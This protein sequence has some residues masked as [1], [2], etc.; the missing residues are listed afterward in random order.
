MAPGAVFNCFPRERKP[1]RGPVDARIQVRGAIPVNICSVIRQASRRATDVLAKD[2]DNLARSFDTENTGGLLSGFLAEEDELDRRALWRIGSWGVGAVG[3]VIVAVLAN[4]SAIG[5][6]REQLAAVDLTRQAQQAQL[7]ARESQNE[8]RRLASAIDTLSGDRDR[9]YSRVT[10][11]EQGL[12]SVTGTIARQ[13]APAPSPTT[14]EPPTAAPSPAPA[15]AVAP[16]ASTQPVPTGTDK[17]VAAEKKPA[18]ADKPPAAI[19]DSSPAMV[20]TVA[21]DPPKKTDAAKSD[22]VKADL[23]KSDPAKSDAAKSDPAKSDPAKA[24]PP[25]ADTPK[26]DNANT[27]AA[28]LDAPKP[29]AATPS[30]PLVASKS[31]MAPP[32]PSAAKLI[33]PLQPPSV[34]TAAPISEVVASTPPAEDADPDEAPKAA[35]QRTEFGVDLGSANSLPGLRALWRGLLKSRSNAPLAALRPIIV[36]KEGSNG[37]GMQLRLVAGPLNDAGAAAKICA[38]L[39]EN[40]RSCETAIFDGQRLSLKGDDP[41]PVSTTKPAPRR[42][43]GGKHA[44]AIVVEEPVKKPEPATTSTIS[45]WFGKKGQ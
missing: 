31:I 17:P 8:T 10:S 38:V 21:K 7:V 2:P 36:V 23:A 12:D 19:T 3:A 9:L 4:Q 33:E 35:L 41:Q 42:R 39:T 5:L 11:L 22:P 24:D 34:I 20:S 18:V 43:G 25:K 16:V 45:S 28:R 44:A 1:V 27:E 14:A 13:A 32:D 15:P 40:K 6:R 37:L 29:P 30:T 26:T